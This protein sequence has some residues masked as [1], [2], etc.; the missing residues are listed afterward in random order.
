MKIER[1]IEKNDKEY[2]QISKSLVV[3]TINSFFCS[4]SSTELMWYITVIFF[5]CVPDTFTQFFTISNT[6]LKS[7]NF[8]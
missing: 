8:K 5:K 6:S 3:L 1:A 4:T 2:P 7:I